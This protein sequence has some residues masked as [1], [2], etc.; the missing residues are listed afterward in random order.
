MFFTLIDQINILQQIKRKK[1]LNDE[2]DDINPP[3]T[4]DNLNSQR[5]P[6][7]QNET[8]SETN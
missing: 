2:I 8:Q 1:A 6:Q 5:R 3:L 7:I 4:T